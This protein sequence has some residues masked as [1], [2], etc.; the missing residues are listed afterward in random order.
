MI[1]FCSALTSSSGDQPFWGSMVSRAGAGP[2]PIPSKDLTADVLSSAIKKAL[3]PACA[4]KAKELSQ[5]ISQESGSESGAES[6]HHELDVDRLRCQLSPTRPAVWR[7]RRTDFRLSAFA[8]TIL[9]HE[10]L[11]DTKDLKLSVLVTLLY[12]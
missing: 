8:A 11:L 7:I 10:R 9:A 6:F 1:E 3:T 2:D 4:E 5:R 12:V